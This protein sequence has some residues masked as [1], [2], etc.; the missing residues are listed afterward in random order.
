MSAFQLLNY[1]LISHILIFVLLIGVPDAS[2]KEMYLYVGILILPIYLF[3]WS[4]F[5]RKDKYRQILIYYNKTENVPNSKII[6]MLSILYVLSSFISLAI[7]LYF[8]KK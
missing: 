3:N 4:L 8:T 2:R 1:C 5:I 7:V 6:N